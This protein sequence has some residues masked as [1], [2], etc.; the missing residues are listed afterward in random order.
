MLCEYSTM[1][2]D[3]RARIDALLELGIGSWAFH[4]RAKREPAPVVRGLLA[5]SSH[6]DHAAAVFLK[7]LVD[8]QLDDAALEARW[9]RAVR[10]LA[11][12]DTSY[13]WGSKK[14]AAKLTGVAEDPDVLAAVQAACAR[15]SAASIDFLG[16]LAIDASEASVD[17]LLPHVDRARVQGDALLDRLARLGKVVRRGSPVSALL[18]RV[19]AQL[20]ARQAASPALA[21]AERIGFGTCKTFWFQIAFGSVQ[22][23]GTVP[24]FQGHVHV[25]S[26]KALWLS[27]WLTRLGDGVE[28]M[29]HA[30]FDSDGALQDPFGLGRCA[31]DALPRWVSDASRVLG[32]EWRREVSIRSSL[33]G[34]KRE[35][36]RVWFLDGT[37]VG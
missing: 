11:D 14:R 8:P 19:N 32:V 30:R 20:D 27:V 4:R 18:D 9:T 13:G 36:L 10:A 26:R 2:D 7:A 21:F 23:R 31:V 33:R 29:V 24:R 6:D 12:L 5:A 28:P 37:P 1:T 22:L 25:D 35:Q 3:E 34:R 17:A 16:V 15:A